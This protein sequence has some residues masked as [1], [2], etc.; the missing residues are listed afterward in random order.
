MANPSVGVIYGLSDPNTGELRYVGQTRNVLRDR[1]RR[2]IY[3]AVHQIKK[4]HC[5]QWLL[6]LGGA[7][8]W[9]AVLDVVPACE[10]NRVEHE[11]ITRMR[12]EGCRLTNSKD[13]AFG[14][15]VSRYPSV[16]DDDVVKAYA[17]GVPTTQIAQTFRTCKKRVCAL[18]RSKGVMRKHTVTAE[19]R[20][21]A[22]RATKA[23]QAR[24]PQSAASLQKKSC[25][26]RKTWKRRHEM[27]PIRIVDDVGNVFLSVSD[28]ARFWGIKGSAHVVQVLNG[29]R[30]T[31]AGHTFA[32][33]E[34]K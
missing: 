33:I 3:D 8:P 7:K 15:H 22:S 20:A 31:C 19:A 32:R 30:K 29:E 11:W 23:A 24:C 5:T 1:V 34:V 21:N 17:S 13:G 26:L 18:L 9:V 14:G 16:S 12:R 10:L 27:S 25:S 4:T 2:H 28:A 6:S